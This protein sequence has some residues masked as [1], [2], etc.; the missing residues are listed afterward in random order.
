MAWVRLKTGRQAS[1]EEIRAFCRARISHHKVP[2]HVR[3]LDS[4]PMTVTGKIQKYVLREW[5][6]REFGI[7]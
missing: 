7:G 3:F 6:A 4:F 5:A 1:E 2:R